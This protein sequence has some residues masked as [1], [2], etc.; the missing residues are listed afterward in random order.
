MCVLWAPVARFL[1]RAS[2]FACQRDRIV[3][4]FD[5]CASDSVVRFVSNRKRQVLRV[6]GLFALC[7]TVAVGCSMGADSAVSAKSERLLIQECS[8]NLKKITKSP[9]NAG[10]LQALAKF[11]QKLTM[12]PRNI[13][14][15]DS[16]KT[17]KVALH[18]ATVSHVKRHVDAH[19]RNVASA[20]KKLAKLALSTLQ[21]DGN[22][23]TADE[24]AAVPASAAPDDA[25]TGDDVAVED[26]FD[27][28][29]HPGW[30]DKN[31]E[32][33]DWAVWTLCGPVLT[34]TAAMWIFYTYGW[35]WALGTLL[36]L[37]GVD[38]FGFYYNV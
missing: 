2:V 35:Q 23:T 33:S 27:K 15:T 4:G 5:F 19:V 36:V 6:V 7:A 20:H 9:A 11:T 1:V 30:D 38:M 21:D 28:E 13:T 25:A 10:G 29:A 32:T 31:W 26:R 12:F 17:K 34:M 14:G 8:G 3:S 37:V 24:D 16:V 18:A 22:S